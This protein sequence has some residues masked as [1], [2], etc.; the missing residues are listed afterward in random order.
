[1]VPP[2]LQGENG[3]GRGSCPPMGEL[4]INLVGRSWCSH[5]CMGKHTM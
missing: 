4:S 5:Y 3:E 1:V 2:P